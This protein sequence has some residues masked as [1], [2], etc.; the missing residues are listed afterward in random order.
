LIEDRNP[1]AWIISFVFISLLNRGSQ[2]FPYKF[3][4]LSI[5]NIIDFV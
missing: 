2:V 5:I 3:L 4:L 1:E